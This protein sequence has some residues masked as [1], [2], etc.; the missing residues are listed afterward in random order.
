MQQDLKSRVRRGAFA[1]VFTAGILSVALLGCDRGPAP[2]PAR[3]PESAP[4][5]GSG[6]GAA[7][8][9]ST[10]DVPTPAT[11]FVG[12]LS[13]IKPDAWTQQP[14]ATKMRLAEFVTADGCAIVYFDDLG[15]IKPGEAPTTE[16]VKAN[17]DRWTGQVQASDGKPVVPVTREIQRE[18]FILTTFEATG[19][20][21]EGMPGGPTTPKPE[22]TFRGAVIRTPDDLYFV[23]MTGPRAAM[24]AHAASWNTMLDTVKA[25]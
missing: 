1:I 8:I 14:P 17:I 19:T 3:G 12:A 6:S 22:T 16:M 18:G 15:A 13:F 2:G 25:K 9:R 21:Q 11:R 7:Q 10:N 4:A 20:Y 24:D 5:A 23:R